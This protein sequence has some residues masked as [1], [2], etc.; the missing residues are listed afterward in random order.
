VDVSYPFGYGLSYTTFE[1]SD[2]AIQ[3]NGD[4]FTVSVKVKNTGK[5]EGKESVQLYVAAPK[6]KLDKPKKE[7]KSFAKT[8]TLKPGESETLTMTVSVKDLASFNTQKSQW[9]T[10]KGTYNFMIG[11]SVADIKAQLKGKVS[12]QWT[13][14]VRNV[15]KPGIAINELKNK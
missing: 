1:Y 3:N 15:L 8:K 11:A 7:L 10:D 2:A 13:K 9:E 4:S 6:G 12:K 14:T 5:Y